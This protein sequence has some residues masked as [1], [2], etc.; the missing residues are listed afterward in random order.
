MI[1]NSIWRTGGWE[2]SAITTRQMYVYEE[3]IKGESSSSL[4]TTGYIGI[5]NVSDY[6]YASSGCYEGVLIKCLR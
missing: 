2:K 3:S 1:E 4:I 5:M 6:G